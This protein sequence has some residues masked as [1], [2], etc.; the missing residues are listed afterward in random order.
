MDIVLWLLHNV[1]IQR[2]E[3]YLAYKIY[4]ILSNVLVI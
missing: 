3:N 4:V 1:A 2:C